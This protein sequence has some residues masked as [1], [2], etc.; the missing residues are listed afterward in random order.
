MPIVDRYGPEIEWDLRERIQ[1]DLAEFFRGDRP[2]SQLGRF[3]GQL[4]VHPTS[5]FMVA[6]QNDP[7]VADE[8]LRQRT[9]R[10]GRAPYRPSAYEWDLAAQ[11]RK[12]TIDRLG[13]IEAILG[14]QPLPK[15]TKRL[16]PPR[17]FP[18][19]VSAIEQ[20]EARARLL[21]MADL[22]R[23]VELAQE[24]YRQQQANEGVRDGG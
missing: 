10:K 2:W 14:S 18:V 24:R 22:D 3:L 8:I 12:Q 11:Q 15:G 20:A 9:K 21:N 7:T 17:P 5:H 23:E 1:V 16:K 13:E 6:Q 19:P 4:S